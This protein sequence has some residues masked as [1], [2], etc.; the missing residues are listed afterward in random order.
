MAEVALVNKYLLALVIGGILAAIAVAILLVRNRA[1]AKV[2]RKEHMAKENLID[3]IPDTHTT[4]SEVQQKELVERLVQF[5]EQ[6]KPYLESHIT[7]ERLA[8]KL[9]VSPKLLSSTINNQLHV[10][11]FE[12]IGNYRV[13]EAKKRLADSGLRQQSINEIMKSCGFNSKSVFNQAFKK[14]V[15]VTPSHYRQQHLH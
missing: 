1:L 9:Q 5:M 11:F 7:V 13:A 15:G 12:L 6:N 4:H 10:N 14:A 2:L 8:N 3:P